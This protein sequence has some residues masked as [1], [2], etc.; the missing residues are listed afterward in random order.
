MNSIL[1]STATH[2]NTVQLVPC[3]KCKD[4][5]SVETA[6]TTRMQAAPWERKAVNELQK[7]V[8]SSKALTIV[9]TLT[10]ASSQRL[11]RGPSECGQR[12]R[13]D[14]WR[15]THATLIHTSL[16]QTLLNCF[17][18]YQPYYR[19]A[20]IKHSYH[21]RKPSVQRI[22]KYIKMPQTRTQYEQK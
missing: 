12:R 22:K 17:I 7:L 10:L 19:Q 5:V 21:I 15:S 13:R 18:T 4:L 8:W 14:G 3:N 11:P 6:N 1:F 2:Q 16:L 20:I 9:P